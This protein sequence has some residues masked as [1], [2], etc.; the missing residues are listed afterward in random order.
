MVPTTIQTYLDSF[1]NYELK[2]NQLSS[3][4]LKPD[5]I[6]N[7]L[8]RLGNPQQH[9]KF[10]HVTGSKGKGSV[11]SFV[12]NILKQAGYKIGLFTSPHIQDV[13]ERIRL[14]SSKK[15]PSHS[16]IFCDSISD[17]DMRIIL[18]EI[19]PSL[20]AMRHREKFGSLSYFEV[21]TA[22][23]LYYFQKQKVDFAIFEVGL[24]GRLDATNVIDA[25]VCALTSIS[26]EHTQQLGNSLPAIAYEKS[27]IIKEKNKYAICSQQQKEVFD[28]IKKRCA[29]M[30]SRMFCIGE[31]IFYQCLNQN[32]EGQEVLV[33]GLKDSYRLKTP[34]LG[35]H[36]A[37]NAALAVGIIE[38]LILEGHTINKKSIE[39]GVAS[40]FWPVR[41]EIVQHNPTVI[42]DCAH[43]PDSA[44]KIEK[45]LNS[46]FPQEKIILVLGIS[47]DKNKRGIIKHLTSNADKVI[48]TKAN[49]PRAAS[50]QEEEIQAFF[51]GKFL[52]RTT[53][54]S[55]AME[56]ALRTSKETGI[57]LVCGSLFLVAEARD[58]MRRY[59]SKNSN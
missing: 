50:F 29:Q 59:P 39:E 33:K 10:V 35:E 51:E 6:K 28:V 52:E 21:L 54:V 45:T 48:L 9:L 30:K 23:A 49:H 7:L 27:A 32:M 56:L 19:K 25:P 14:L 43:N 4:E 40:V 26:L 36:Q 3:S 37:A 22:L 13:N 2:R 31:H 47:E 53:N 1:I 18:E 38:A 46:L 42:L 16:G 15:E 55:E 12:A 57:I 8:E 34:L 5:R 20:E 11:C 17:T 58:F 41:F 44:F 24:G